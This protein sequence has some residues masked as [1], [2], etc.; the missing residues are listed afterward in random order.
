MMIDPPGGTNVGIALL[1]FFKDRPFD[2]EAHG[3][4]NTR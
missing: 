1:G 2:T 4:Q 3:G